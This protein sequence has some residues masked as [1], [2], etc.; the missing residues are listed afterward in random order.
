MYYLDHRSFS[1]ESIYKKQAEILPKVTAAFTAIIERKDAEQYE[2]TG[3]YLYE[4]LSA[5]VKEDASMREKCRRKGLPETAES[6]LRE[7][8]DSIGLRVVCL[9]LNDVYRC[10]ELIRAIPGVEI[11]EEKDYIKV[12]KPNGYRS[13]HL[14]LRWTAPFP[15][16]DGSEPGTF[17]MEVQL[18]TIAMDT[19]AALEHEI[20]YKQKPENEALIVRELKRCADELASCDVSMQAIRDMA[21][22]NG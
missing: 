13:Y 6:A 2:E 4:H 22:S 11:V 1:M 14:Q 10:V 3:Q 18:R 20:K 19:W 17:N 7:I 12:S 9:F 8:Y 16:L 5:R 15:D 21:R